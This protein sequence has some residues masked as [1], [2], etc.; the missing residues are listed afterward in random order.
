[1]VKL[2]KFGNGGS[3]CLVLRNK[4]ITYVMKAKL[5]CGL[6]TTSS[7]EPISLMIQ[8]AFRTMTQC[9]QSWKITVYSNSI[10]L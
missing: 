6:A 3:I 9:C 4:I 7:T 1:M 2:P 10:T 5:L 8:H